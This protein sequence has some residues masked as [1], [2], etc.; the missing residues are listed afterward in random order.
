MKLTKEQRRE[1]NGRRVYS[2]LVKRDVLTQI[3]D[4]ILSASD[5]KAIVVTVKNSDDI[6]LASITLFDPIDNEYL[7]Q[8]ADQA[9]A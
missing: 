3:R 9:A 2:Q 1:I 5:P 8:F 7:N 4:L 6:E